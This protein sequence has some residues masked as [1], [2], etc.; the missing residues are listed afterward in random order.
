MEYKKRRRENSP[1]GD[2]GRKSTQGQVTWHGKISTCPCRGRQEERRGRG[3]GGSTEKTLTGRAG[4]LP[5]A[6]AGAQADASRSRLL[7]GRPLRS[8]IPLCPCQ[9]P[10]PK[11]TRKQTH[12]CGNGLRPRPL[13]RHPLSSGRLWDKGAG[14]TGW[15]RRNWVQVSA[16]TLKGRPCWF[17]LL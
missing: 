6:H 2:T 14:D 11:R 5:W 4:P 17:L 13:S 8:S 10:F 16:L 7:G 1:I 12:L 15:S 3:Q 9:G